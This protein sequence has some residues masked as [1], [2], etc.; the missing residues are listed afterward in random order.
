MVLLFRKMKTKKVIKH[1]RLQYHRRQE[2]QT[3][4]IS[5]AYFDGLVSGAQF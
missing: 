2:C 3:D 1:I 4:F 5:Y